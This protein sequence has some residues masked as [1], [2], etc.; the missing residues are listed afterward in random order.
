MII[1]L[2]HVARS[3]KDTAAH[4]LVRDLGFERRAFADKLKQ[5]AVAADPIVTTATQA[6]NVGSGKGRL[7][8]VVRGMGLEQAKDVY[9]EVRRFLQDLGAGARE[10]FGDNFWIDMCLP[11]VE[12]V[13][14]P[15]SDVVVSDVRY[16]NE[17]DEI[18]RRGGKLIR[19]NRP[20][21]YAA[22][23]ETETALVDFDWDE[24]VDNDGSVQDLEQKIVKLVKG[25]T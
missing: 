25:W 4:A 3:G 18:R 20:G 12:W 5:L 19:I 9:P 13:G 22:G 6:T 7:N 23:H 24:E 8:W 21:M 17:A 14:S 2:G 16:E 11:E 10:V 15:L 1:G